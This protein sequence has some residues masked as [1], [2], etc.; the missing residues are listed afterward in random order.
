MYNKKVLRDAL[1]RLDS[2]KPRAQQKDRVINDK[3]LP[4][5]STEGYK[6]GPPP[7]G[8]HYRILGNVISNP[9]PYDI[10]AVGSNGE[11]K[12]IAAGD[13]TNHEF[14][15]NVDY[16]DEFAKMQK[17]GYASIIKQANMQKSKFVDIP[18]AK[19]YPPIYLSDPNDP[20]IGW[21]SEAGNQYLY[22]PITP[23]ASP[24][25][26]AFVPPT[27]TDLEFEPP[28]EPETQW[29]NSNP[30]LDVEQREPEPK[31]YIPEFKRQYRYDPKSFSNLWGLKPRYGHWVDV[32]VEAYGGDISIPQLNQRAKGGFQD[33]IN[34]HRK[35]LRDWTYGASIGTLHEAE[36][37]IEMDLT[38]EEIEQYKK[39]GYVV[40]ELPKAQFG[41]VGYA[42][43]PRPSGLIPPKTATQ[44][45]KEEL[46]KGKGP[47]REAAKKVTQAATERKQFDKEVA[48]QKAERNAQLFEE[49]IQKEVAKKYGVSDAAQPV[50]WLWT[51]PLGAGRAGL[52]AAYGLGESATAAL[53]TKIPGLAGTTV[54]Q[55]M[56]A[57]FIGKGLYDL[58]STYR[59]WQDVAAGKKDWKDAAIKTGFN[60]L[61]FLGVGE[62][63]EGLKLLG[64]DV[65]ASSQL[66]FLL[67]KTLKNN[68]GRFSNIKQGSLP[69][70]IAPK[71]FARLNEIEEAMSINAYNSPNKVKLIQDFAK[72]TT[73]NDSQL[74]RIFGKS[75]SEILRGASKN[76]GTTEIIPLN[77]SESVIDV[78]GLTVPAYQR[79]E[80]RN[81]DRVYN[82]MVGN[83]IPSEL[84]IPAE[85]WG[86][87]ANEA[88][89]KKGVLSEFKQ[90]PTNIANMFRPK[91]HDVGYTTVPTISASAYQSR[92]EMLTDLLKKIN[93]GMSKAEIDDIVTGSLNTS[94]NSYLPQ[95]DYIFKNAGTQGLSEPLFLGYQ[96]MNKAGFLSQAHLPEE[97]Q[98]EY[99]K[100]HLNKLQNRSGK[101]LN[102]GSL[103]P[104]MDKD[105]TIWLPQYGLRKLSNE[106]TGLK[107]E[108]GG[109]IETEL[110][111]KEIDEY[112]K[113]GYIVEEY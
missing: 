52:N 78:E 44:V 17:G 75:K 2:A 1:N 82:D 113:R 105:K 59:A 24:V 109:Y 106:Y 70:N 55:A 8:M 35:L 30:E 31:T 80:I 54:G 3:L 91:I 46:A 53:A 110:T 48:K 27:I 101:Q 9:T 37:G 107:K 15:D 99:L 68:A 25:S 103:P 13:I 33:D 28:I 95:M 11:Q 89:T 73:L 42:A 71:D 86:T 58:P 47:T 21:Y 77:T 16:V 112:K 49:N 66:P 50:D 26:L 18:F 39:G 12:F 92:R 5:I 74:T 96:P 61:D 63:M 60:A 100:H 10:H 51:L 38:P 41:P 111:Q 64:Q 29:T 14:D 67:N 22:K 32:P 45:Q 69:V 87:L 97:M 34:K 81:F 7:E 23:K 65:K 40:D 20:R 72:K 57:G 88:L 19:T 90:M 102:L 93:E 76:R 85:E 56:N 62:A 6:Q 94:Y 83:T 104:Y 84:I 98:F 36:Y 43:A 4:F 79:R 108:E